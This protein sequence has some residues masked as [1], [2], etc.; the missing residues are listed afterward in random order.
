MSKMDLQYAGC[1][2]PCGQPPSP[3]TVL[4]H[5]KTATYAVMYV[6]VICGGLVNNQYGEETESGQAHPP[7]SVG[8]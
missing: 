2:A 7:M 6:K 1:H 5:S 8:G 3:L 4:Q